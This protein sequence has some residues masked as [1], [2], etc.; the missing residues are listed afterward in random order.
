MLQTTRTASK[1]GVGRVSRAPTGSFHSSAHL[2]P[3]FFGMYFIPSRW[4][5]LLPQLKILMNE[6]ISLSK[7]REKSKLG[8]KVMKEV[9][10]DCISGGSWRELRRAHVIQA[11]S[12][13]RGWGGRISW[14]SLSC[15]LHLRC[16]CICQTLW[17]NA[18]VLL[19]LSYLALL[20]ILQDK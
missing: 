7:Y 17:L 4:I 19:T 5:I 1:G 16:A 12:A 6:V 14:R 18:S 11:L 3:H 20:L 8:I 10:R 2:F 9:W 15:F 13:H